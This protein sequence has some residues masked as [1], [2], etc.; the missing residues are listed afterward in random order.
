MAEPDFG[1]ASSAVRAAWDT[2]AEFWDGR[3]GEGNTF[4][5]TLVEPGVLQLLEVQPG[6]RVLEIACGNG[7][8][9]RKLSSLGARVTATDFSPKMLARAQAHTEPFNDRVEYRVTDATNETE[10]RALGEHEFD[11]VVCNMALMDMS[12]IEPL[13]RAVPYLLKPRGRMVFATMHPCFN[14]N[15]PTFLAESTD[16]NGTIVETRALKLTRYLSAESVQG[17]A[18]LGQPVSQYYFHRPLH[19]LL[20]AG[21]RAG[22]VLDGLV[23][24]RLPNQEA[25]PR[26][27][28]WLNYHEF[29][30]VL[31]ARLR[32]QRDT[33]P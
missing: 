8:F 10:L 16:D 27:A 12:S 29:P 22:L 13:F 14:S 7:Q 17:L 31:V 32:A 20:G 30:P 24:P 6:E 3:M 21:F 11:A 15:N 28:S 26:W 18:I 1:V 25:S 33:S 23:E 19:E 5:R 9:A 2:N 4:H